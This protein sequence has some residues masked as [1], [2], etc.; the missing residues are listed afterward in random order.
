MSPRWKP[1]RSLVKAQVIDTPSFTVPGRV[2]GLTAGHVS[3]RAPNP[4]GLSDWI[5]PRGTARTHP[6]TPELQDAM[7]MLGVRS[8]IERTAQFGRRRGRL[9][10]R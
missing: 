8:G 6:L 4:L 1:R 2:P 10:P 3:I 9:P 7:S 5:A